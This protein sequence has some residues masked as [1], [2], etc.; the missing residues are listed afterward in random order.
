MGFGVSKGVFA[1]ELL[2]L[3]VLVRGDQVAQVTSRRN[4]LNFRNRMSFFRCQGMDVDFDVSICEEVDLSLIQ[5]WW[6]L[7]LFNRLRRQSHLLTDFMCVVF[8]DW[9]P[10]ICRVLEDERHQE[11]ASELGVEPSPLQ[12]RQSRVI[13]AQQL[14]RQEPV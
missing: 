11:F 6:N 13:L 3:C 10:F 14:R 8:P 1:H 2:K 4:C 5:S 12:K 7:L 9:W